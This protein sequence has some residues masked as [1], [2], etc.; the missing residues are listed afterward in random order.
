MLTLFLKVQGFQPAQRE[1]GVEFSYMPF[2]SPLGHAKNRE[3]Y[4]SEVAR[5][6]SRDLEP[7]E[8]LRPQ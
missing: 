4:P 5:A 3:K 1:A 7:P 2:P 6:Q 8:R